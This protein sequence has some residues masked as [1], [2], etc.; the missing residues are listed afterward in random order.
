MINLK[1]EDL[2][3]F[4][5]YTIPIYFYDHRTPTAWGITMTK[6]YKTF[7]DKHEGNL[8]IFVSLKICSYE[9]TSIKKFPWYLIKEQNLL[10]QSK[11]AILKF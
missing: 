8:G 7:Q 4:L 10:L 6:A 1:I 11:N 9:S 2:C 3:F 5:F